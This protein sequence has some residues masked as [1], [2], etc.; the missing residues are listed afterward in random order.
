MYIQSNFRYPL[1]E[2]FAGA[3]RAEDSYITFG[4]NTSFTNNSATTGGNLWQ[5]GL[6]SGKF[7]KAFIATGLS[8]SELLRLTW[9]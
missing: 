9:G 5:Q 8:L 4:G 1:C 2:S 7:I 3:M 6:R